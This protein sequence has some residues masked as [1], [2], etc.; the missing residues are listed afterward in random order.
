MQIHAS[1]DPH[2]GEFP[3]HMNPG[4][5]NPFGV[6]HFGED[7]HLNVENDED[8]DRIV[9][10]AMR[11]KAMRAA[12]GTP[13][14]HQPGAGP[15]RSHC[16][17]C[18]MLPDAEDHAAPAV[19][20]AFPV[21][22]FTSSST[23]TLAPCYQ[24]TEHDPLLAWG[25]DVRCDT[26]AHHVGTVAERAR[27]GARKASALGEHP[28]PVAASHYC[29]SGNCDVVGDGTGDEP[30]LAAVT[31]ADHIA[32]TGCNAVHPD[33]RSSCTGDKCHMPPHRD[34]DGD[35]WTGPVRARLHDAAAVDPFGP[36]GYKLHKPGCE[37]WDC[38]A[39]ICHR[40][41][42]ATDSP[43]GRIVTD[44]HDD[45]PV[46]LTGQVVARIDD[47]TVDVI[48]QAEKGGGYTGTRTREPV[49]ALRPAD[50]SQM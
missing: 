44:A 43:V 27:R 28:Y 41:P 42:V 2:E 48:W 35:E 46:A 21:A 12:A 10:A 20:L 1:L 7:F 5:G 15:H 3:V 36:E 49:E 11:I 19:D 16:T 23:G 40:W 17:V 26:E 29:D 18:G 32:E 50:R 45:S 37:C 33:K 6:L 24:P 9:R 13:H 4:R 34:D 25:K 8:A 30:A 39:E 14:G 38:K 31:F 47:E 22:E